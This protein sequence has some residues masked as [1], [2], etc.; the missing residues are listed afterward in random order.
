MNEADVGTSS[1]LRDT[2]N[3][4]L[5]VDPV[6]VVD[7][8]LVD[9]VFQ[10]GGQ[11]LLDLGCGLGGY[12]KTLA[13]RGRKVTALDV[14]EKYVAIAKQIGVDAKLYDGIRL[15]LPDKSV[16]TIFMIEV[17]E[18]IPNPEFLIAELQRVTRRNLIVTVPNCSQSF[19]APVVFHHML[20]VD[21]KNFFNL[22]TLHKLLSPQFRSVRIEQVMPLD[23]MLAS[24]LLPRWLFR[25]WKAAHQR[26]Y[27]KD[28]YYFRLI[29]DA[30]I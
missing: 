28:R 24:D 4:Y 25:I 22:S 11:E 14:N 16:D 30:A 23:A 5:G 15:P 1:G 8:S 29:A 20:D 3:W 6:S 17:M 21:H 18:H 10:H 2:Q 13:M 7:H 12:A 26:G 19:T 9:Y 27:I